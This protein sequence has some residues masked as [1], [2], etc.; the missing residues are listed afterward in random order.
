MLPSYA[1]KASHTFFISYSMTSHHNVSPFFWC[2]SL[3]SLTVRG[4]RSLYLCVFYQYL[5]AV[6][7]MILSLLLSTFFI[8]HANAGSSAIWLCT[9]YSSSCTRKDYLTS[10]TW[11]QVELLSFHCMETYHPLVVS[12]LLLFP[13]YIWITESPTLICVASVCRSMMALN[14]RK[15]CPSCLTWEST[16][17]VIALYVITILYPSSYSTP[18][19]H[20]SR[21]GL[22]AVIPIGLQFLSFN[23]LLTLANS[24]QSSCLSSASSML[25]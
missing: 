8:Q 11:F 19:I 17:F 20:M 16:L 24:G 10:L 18:Y 2:I 15:L 21:I 7:D 13:L 14:N 9:M 5:Q 6:L 1:S 25:T 22:S 12:L 3:A 23:L 4:M